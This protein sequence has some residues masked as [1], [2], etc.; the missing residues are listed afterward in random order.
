M[1]CLHRD[2]E[3]AWGCF[4]LIPSFDFLGVLSASA[5]KI[6]PDPSQPYNLG[7]IRPLA[8]RGGSA[9]NHTEAG[10]C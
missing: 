4:K 6:V 1:S 2:T 9:V 8:D 3:F 10:S 5:L 7:L